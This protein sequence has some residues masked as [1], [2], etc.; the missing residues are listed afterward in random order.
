MRDFTVVNDGMIRFWLVKY[1][2]DIESFPQIE[3]DIMKSLIIDGPQQRN[4]IAKTIN[5]PLTTTYDHLVKLMNIDW[6]SK[7]SKPTGKRG[8]PPVFYK[9]NINRHGDVNG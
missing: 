2:H 5:K 3:I 9:S 1:G 6:V 8:H 7:Y 4:D